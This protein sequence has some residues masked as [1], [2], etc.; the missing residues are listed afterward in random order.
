MRASRDSAT[1]QFG[2]LSQRDGCSTFTTSIANGLASTI[3]CPAWTICSNAR[4]AMALWTGH[5][6]FSTHRAALIL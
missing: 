5:R 6:S 2:V 3:W 4:N 1:P